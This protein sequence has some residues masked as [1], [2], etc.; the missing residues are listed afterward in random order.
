MNDVVLK[1]LKEQGHETVST[2][3]YNWIELW[4]NWWKNEV[5]FHKYHDQ[6]GEERKLYNLGMAKRISEDWASILF[7]ERDEITTEAQ[8]QKQTKANN[9]YLD[10]QLKVLKVYKDLPIAIEKAMAMGTAGAIL[11]VKYVKTDKQ[12]SLL[13]DGRTKLDIIYVGASQIV[14]LR[15]E[16]GKIIDVAIASEDN[17]ENKKQYYIEIHKLDYSKKLEK[18]IYNISNVYLDE[19]GKEIERKGIAKNYNVNSSVPLFSILKPAIANPLDISYNNINGLG[20]S[21]YG[22]AIDQ[23]KACDITYNN[24]VMDFYLGGKKVFYNKKI[25][26]TKTVQIKDE[27]GEVVRE[28][29]I[30]LY[31]DDITRQQWK[32]YGNEMINLNEEPAITEYN[33]ELRVEEDKEG[34]QFA[35]NMLSFKCGLGTKYYEFN[36]GT[37]VT[38]T[39]YMGDRQD[40]IVNA[41]KHRKNVD[42]FVSGICKAILLLGRILFKENVTEDCIVKVV[43]KD[44]FMVDTETAKQEFRQDIAQGIRQAWEYRVKFFGEDME[45][46]KAM[47]KDEEIEDREGEQETASPEYLNLIEFNDIVELY[48]KLNI[49]ITADIIKRVAE[50]QDITETSKKQLKILK[51]TNGIEIFNKALEET[52]MLTTQTKKALKLLF[53]DMAK[54]DIDGYKELYQ[55]RNQPF[56]LNE[57]QYKILNEGLRTTNKA[58]KNFTNTIAFKS[59][60]AYVEAIDMAYMKIASGAFDYTTAINMA[61]QELAS[62][63][64]TLKDKLG[65]NVQLEVA[66]RRNVMTGIQQTANNINRDIEEYL[67][68]DGYEVTAHLGARPTHAEE[69]GKQFAITKESASKYGVGLWE[70]VAD[71]WEEYNC[72]HTYFGIILG[73]SEPVYTNKELKEFREATVEWHGKKIP[74]YEATQ[75]QRQLENAIRKKK[76]TVQTLEKANLD[77][78]KAKGQ[79]AQ[80][81]K[82]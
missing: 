3:Y 37:V 31:P 71:L 46:A 17:I 16:H 30:E 64:I 38:A 11:R 13:V 78:K 79:L 76:R 20:F 58:L 29:E 1:Y 6:T 35:L 44:G 67:G 63:G 80:L 32:T 74:Y 39:Q 75:K 68:C 52:S 49:E 2:D 41:N 26:E 54:E 4:K 72:R 7:T 40:L 66:V 22:T 33:P 45:T 10:K 62:K 47:V 19:N 53:E 60:Q 43:D 8:T 65:R 25:V 21:V 15:V 24:F 55:Y 14:P 36:G 70:D 51:Q 48:N 73:I 27:N 23:L 61:C 50:M 77:N 57:T 5:D 81:Q 34:I 18:E 59:Q 12:G 28:E 82:K 42:E 56:K 9:E 69:Q